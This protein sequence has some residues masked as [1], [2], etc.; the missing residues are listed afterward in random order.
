M[1]L[2]ITLTINYMPVIAQNVWKKGQKVS[3]SQ[4][5]IEPQSKRL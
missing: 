1:F 4:E 5:N 2:H 3:K